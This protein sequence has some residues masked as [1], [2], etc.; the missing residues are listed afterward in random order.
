MKNIITLPRRLK[1]KQYNTKA[2]LIVQA[3]I[4]SPPPPP[5]THNAKM[6]RKLI[7]VLPLKAQAGIYHSNFEPFS[8]PINQNIFFVTGMWQQALELLVSYQKI[9][10]INCFDP[11]SAGPPLLLLSTDHV[12]AFPK[13]SHVCKNIFCL[14]LL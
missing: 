8:F 1:L 6:D 12:A 13:Q 9:V 7:K 4:Y 3:S 5:Q 14:I 11:R 10:D 2:I